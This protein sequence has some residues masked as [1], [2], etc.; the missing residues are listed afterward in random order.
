MATVPAV[1][2]DSRIP[3]QVHKWIDLAKSLQQCDTPEKRR[4]LGALHAKFAEERRDNEEAMKV[5]VAP[6]L[7]RE[8]DARAPYKVIIDTC[9]VWERYVEGIMSGYDREERRKAMEKQAEANRKAEERNRLAEAKAE[10]HGTEPVRTAPKIVETVEKT[11]RND[12]GSSSTKKPVKR[13]YMDGFLHDDDLSKIKM[14]DPRMA[15]VEREHMLLNVKAIDKAVKD[16]G[17][18]DALKAQGIIV[19]DDFEY[20]GRGAKS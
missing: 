6:I 9:S 5:C 16:G 11:V 7:K 4:Q 3:I 18:E 19:Y 8:R 10:E 15:K 17:K 13:W 2:L 20:T 1:Q 12:D 14:T